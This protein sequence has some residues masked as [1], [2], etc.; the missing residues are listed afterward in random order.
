MR[1]SQARISS[2]ADVLPVC[3]GQAETSK[4][5]WGG[6]RSRWASTGV[7]E[8]SLPSRGHPGNHPG[9]ACEHPAAE[10]SRAG[11]VS[12][13]EQQPSVAQAVQRGPVATSRRHPSLAA[14]HLP[15]HNENESSSLVDRRR[16]LALNRAG[17]PRGADAEPRDFL[18]RWEERGAEVAWQ[19]SCRGS[20]CSSQHGAAQR[21]R[22]LPSRTAPRCLASRC[23]TPTHTR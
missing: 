14:A 12:E 23:R 6:G 5:W 4:R 8:V 16:R 1:R 7:V 11:I 9:R 22:S 3:D 10:A 15:V 2:S 17:Q 21:S 20:R 13:R 18:Q 19:G